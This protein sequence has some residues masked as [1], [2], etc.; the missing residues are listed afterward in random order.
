MKLVL[1]A[2]PKKYVLILQ[3]LF[4][5]IFENYLLAF[6][7]VLICIS[8]FY[9]QAFAVE[10]L[11]DYVSV[12]N[13]NPDIGK[14]IMLAFV[15]FGLNLIRIAADVSYWTVSLRTAIRLRSGTLTLVFKKVA[16]LRSLQDRS[17][18]EVCIRK[19]IAPKGTGWGGGERAVGIEA[20]WFER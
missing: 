8:S 18:G 19:D 14:G 17:V 2:L 7:S 10:E 5:S 15:I 16:K 12:K 3:I 1:G 13:D 11:L 6:E 4:G 20:T 9:V